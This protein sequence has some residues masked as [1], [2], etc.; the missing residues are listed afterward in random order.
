MEMALLSIA[1]GLSTTRTWPALGFGYPLARVAFGQALTTPLEAPAVPLRFQGG[2][3]R[4]RTAFHLHLAD[5]GEGRHP[6][7]S[8][9]D[10]LATSIPTLRS[11]RQFA[12]FQVR[13]H[14]ART[15]R[16]YDLAPRA[17]DPGGPPAPITVIA[18]DQGH[19]GA[20]AADQPRHHRGGEARADRRGR[21][22]GYSPPGAAL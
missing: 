11:V 6:F 1:P 20:S 22:G 8:E 4:A 17:R 2:I 3:V 16:Q 7:E 13:D 12:L 10:G 9:A 5:N 19:S 21:A 18:Q 14:P 15:A